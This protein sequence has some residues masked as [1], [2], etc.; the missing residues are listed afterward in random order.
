MRSGRVVNLTVRKICGAMIAGIL[1]AFSGVAATL[2]AERVKIQ[3]DTRRVPIPSV[4]AGEKFLAAFIA[5]TNGQTILA[6]GFGELTDIHD[7]AVWLPKLLDGTYEVLFFISGR[8][9]MQV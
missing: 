6:D 3:L 9:G 8:T 1:A 5:R 2:R 4:T 7:G